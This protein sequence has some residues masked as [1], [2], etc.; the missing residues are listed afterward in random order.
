MKSASK[1]Q[2]FLYISIIFRNFAAVMIHNGAMWAG[3]S[4][5]ENLKTGHCIT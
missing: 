1:V 2:I 4:C 3:K 5:S